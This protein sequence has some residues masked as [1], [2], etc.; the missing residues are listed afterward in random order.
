MPT[1]GTGMPTALSARPLVLAKQEPSLFGVNDLGGS[2]A[3]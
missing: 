2:Q 1:S 3:L